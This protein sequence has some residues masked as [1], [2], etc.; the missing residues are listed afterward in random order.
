MYFILQVFIRDP[1]S[2]FYGHVFIK[3]KNPVKYNKTKFLKVSIEANNQSCYSFAF[4]YVIFIIGSTDV[5]G[6]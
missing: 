1:A 3:K 2:T 6:I 5:L 4:V